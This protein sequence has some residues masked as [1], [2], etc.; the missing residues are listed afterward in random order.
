MQ[1]LPTTPSKSRADHEIEKIKQSLSAKWHISLP[2]RRG[3]WSPS[4]RDPNSLEEKICTSIQFLYFKNA[5]LVEEAINNFETNATVVYSTW[6]FKPRGEIDVVPNGARSTRQPR[7]QFLRKQ[8]ELPAAVIKDLIESLHYHLSLVVNRVQR[9]SIK[10]SSDRHE[11]KDY[12]L[13]LHQE[14]ACTKFKDRS[15][16]FSG[17]ALC[18]HAIYDGSQANAPHNLDQ[19]QKRTEAIK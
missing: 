1:H 13:I 4:H 9:G 18:S 14:P 16:R 12:K 11:C 19:E 2:E 3:H 15:N 5:A 6:Q 17:R 7:E 10:S 8:G